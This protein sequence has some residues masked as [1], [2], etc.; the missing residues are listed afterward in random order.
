MRR[1]GA[2]AALLAAVCASSGAARG[3]G[4]TAVPAPPTRP[5]ATAPA[6]PAVGPTGPLHLRV[7]EAVRRGL[8][9]LYR[10]QGADG[11]WDSRYV[12]QHPGGVEA[13]VVLSA[14]SAGEKPNH[15]KLASGLSFLEGLALRTVYSRAARALVYARL[16]GADYRNRLEEDITWLAD[17]QVRTGG[18]GY[19]PGLRAGK[20]NPLRT[21]L[22][23]TYLAMLALREAE[24]VGV[25]VPSGVW[26][27][28][29]LYWSKAGNPDGGLSYQPPGGPG[30][31]LRGSSYGSMTVAGAAAMHILADRWAAVG[32][33]PFTN[34]GAGRSN[35][36]QFAATIARALKWLAGN[37]ALAK[38]PKWVW[39]PGEAYEYY[40]LW[41]LQA[42]LDEGGIWRI[43]SDESARRAAELIVSRQRADGSWVD[44]EAGADP[45]DDNK[46]TAIR[47][48][49]ALLALT[50]ARGPVVI[51]KLR[52]P[53]EADNDPRDAAQFARWLGRSLGWR[54]SWRQVG[55]GDAN[56][57]F[58]RAPLLYIQTARREYPAELGAKIRRF[59]AG[60]GTVLVQ[61]FAAD[62]AARA[63]AEQYLIKLLPEYHSGN[64]SGNHPI[65][66]LHFKLPTANR[67]RLFGL[68]DACR[69][70]VFVLTTDLSGAWH[71]DR[72]ADHRS[73]FLLAGNLLLYTTDL[74]APPGKLAGARPAAPAGKAVR[75]LAVA[76]VRHVGDWDVCPRAIGRV[77]EVLRRAMSIGVRELPPLDLAAPVSANVTMLWLTGTKAVGLTSAQ[78]RNLKAYLSAGG[79][80]LADS[81]MGGP[82]LT[83]E[84]TAVLTELFGAGSVS[85][86]PPAS[87][88]LTGRFGG[89]IGSDVT[90]VAYTRAARAAE[91]KLTTPVLKCLKLD[92]RIAAVVSPYSVT[93]PL[94]GAATYNCKGLSPPDAGRLAANAVLYAAAMRPGRATSASRSAGR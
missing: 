64:L 6:G 1:S 4:G 55:I 54:A 68:G 89:G 36:M 5:A 7:D 21:D 91:P 86:V 63:A 78:K 47:T 33:A 35:P 24:A 87:P 90:R 67:P 93:C 60:G 66:S 39:G 82:E 65:Y 37:Y 2:V 17:Q 25:K 43:G 49:F 45:G 84:V 26:S 72:W 83:D 48:C 15:P 32:E 18:W 44:P 80:L 40:Y 51:E 85:P 29:R 23:N 30:F 46:L 56:E 12:R 88:L 75:S 20:E 58:A 77:D 81:A 94:E 69:T 31:R 16:K 62:R 3:Q 52:L 13:L 11:S 79:M 92:G 9:Y 38:N 53:G 22:S 73:A 76:R 70:R 41:V 61:P 59:V 57:T 19:G 50:R 71:Q 42:L 74:L 27:R 14:L 28:C 10:R 8:D 34:A